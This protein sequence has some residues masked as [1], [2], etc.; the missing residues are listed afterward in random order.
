KIPCS[1]VYECRVC[2]KIARYS[3]A[4]AIVYDRRTVLIDDIV[5]DDGVGSAGI[6]INPRSL[7]S[8]D[9]VIVNKRSHC[10]IA[11][12]DPKAVTSVWLPFYDI[13]IYGVVGA[14]RN[15]H[16]RTTAP[17]RAV[18]FYYVV[19]NGVVVHDICDSIIKV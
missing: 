18:V 2:S 8:V 3:A 19:S 11:Y 14:S 17:D 15:D 13:A 7:V 9:R 5:F 16:C 4:Y 1:R 10:R 12:S 6:Y